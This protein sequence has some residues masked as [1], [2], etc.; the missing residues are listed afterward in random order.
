[1]GDLPES[2][3]DC[4][5]RMKHSDMFAHRQR[6]DKVLVKCPFNFGEIACNTMLR[7]KDLDNHMIDHN[8]FHLSLL[9][10]LE[11]DAI[12]PIVAM[13][14]EKSTAHQ[15]F[16]A[17]AALKCLARDDVDAQITIVM[18]GAVT[19]LT[20]LLCESTVHWV[21]LAATDALLSFDLENFTCDDIDGSTIISDTAMAVLRGGSSSS[22]CTDNRV[23]EAALRVLAHAA[24]RNT[25]RLRIIEAGIV[26]TLVAL[27]NDTA[28]LGTLDAAFCALIRIC[29]FHDIVS[30]TMVGAAIAR[31]GLFPFIVAQLQLS[32]AAAAMMLIRNLAGSPDNI[33]AIIEAGAANHLMVELERSRARSRAIHEWNERRGFV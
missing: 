31:A 27:L 18:A 12:T 17:A 1:M 30:I 6:C 16:S 22:N 25:N 7:R 9:D 14:C 8:F 11:D 19:E 24:T 5:T 33:V 32:S 10:L 20:A 26:A 15:K 29:T 23:Q 2:C 13:L 28:A 4:F 3:T 21:R